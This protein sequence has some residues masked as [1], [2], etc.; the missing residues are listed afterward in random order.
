MGEQ[1][2]E[3]DTKLEELKTQHGEIRVLKHGALV[4]ACKPCTNYAAMQQY[5]DDA[6]N[7]DKSR[8]EAFKN[9]I[10]DTAVIPE[11]PEEVL[12]L[13]KKRPAWVIK[14]GAEV[15][16]MSGMQDEVETLRGN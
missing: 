8:F 15:S 6:S 2:S 14:M 16:R 13:L 10:V 4:L 12:G 1:K 7:E 11:K 3:L 9:L 5:F